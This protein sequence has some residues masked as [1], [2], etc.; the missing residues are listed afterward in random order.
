MCVFLRGGGGVKKFHMHFLERFCNLVTNRKSGR[1]Q[2]LIDVGRW[3]VRSMAVRVVSSL[4]RMIGGGMRD[5][6]YFCCYRRKYK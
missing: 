6:E 4:G 2:C 3:K 1:V 5:G